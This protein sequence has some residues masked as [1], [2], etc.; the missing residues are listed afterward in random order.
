MQ[1]MHS[2]SSEKQ[3]EEPLYLS[4]ASLAN[5][6]NLST[7]SAYRVVQ[8][9]LPSIRLLN[10]IRVPLDAVEQYERR[11]AAAARKA[12]PKAGDGA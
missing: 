7:A 6:W 1:C 3:Q 12:K 8:A 4:I 5:R 9:E 10:S 11:Q 2:K